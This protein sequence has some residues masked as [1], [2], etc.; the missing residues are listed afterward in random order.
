MDPQ[1]AS[2]SRGAYLCSGAFLSS[3]FKNWEGEFL[4]IS[5]DGRLEV[6]PSCS[7][8]YTRLEDFSGFR[9]S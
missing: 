6:S 5:V 2:L 9:I 1:Q 7:E 4:Q 8:T 3:L